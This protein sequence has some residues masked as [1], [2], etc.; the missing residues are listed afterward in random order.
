MAVRSMT[1]TQTFSAPTQADTVTN[2][3]TQHATTN[4][5]ISNGSFTGVAYTAANA[6]ESIT[7]VWLYVVAVGTGGTV[8]A[9]LQGNSAGYVDI[10]GVAVTVNTTNLKTGGWFYFR[11]A[12]AHV[13]VSG[14][15][16]YYRVKITGAGMTG[17]TTVAADGAGTA[18]SY[19]ATDNRNTAVAPGASDNLIVGGHA[20]AAVTLTLD[21]TQTIGSWSFTGG[22]NTEAASIRCNSGS[23]AID[24]A[25]GGIIADN[26]AANV[27][28]TLKGSIVIRNGGKSYRNNGV[29]VAYPSARTSI[30]RFNLN[31]V[32]GNHGFIK[33]EGGVLDWIGMVKT[34][35][36]VTP[37]TYTSGAGTAAD[38]MITSGDI[39]EV[40][41]E[42]IIFATS[43]N[44][45]NYNECE[46]RF[47]K[48]KNS[49]TSY[50]LS[51]T[52]GGAE[53]ALTY[54]HTAV[55]KVINVERNVK[56]TSTSSTA[57]YFSQNWEVTTRA[58]HTLS[59][60]SFEYVGSTTSYKEGIGVAMGEHVGFCDY[61]VFI[62]RI[63]RGFKT[64]SA[65]AQ[66]YV[67]NIVCGGVSTNT[68]SG[69]SLDAADNQ[70]LNDFVIANEKRVAIGT[71]QNAGSRNTFNRLEM[72][73]CGKDGGTTG[74][75]YAVSTNAWEF[76]NCNF[77]ACRTQAMYIAGAVITVNNCNFG[78][79]GKNQT[80]DI[81]T[82]GG[83]TLCL[84]N[85][86]NFGSDTLINGYTLMVVGSLVRF[87]NIDQ[88]AT[89]MNHEWYTS[90]GSARACMTGL[91]DTQ[92]TPA[93][94]PT[95]RIAAESSD[96]GFSWEFQVP[97]FETYSA[98]FLGLLQRN[99]TF[100]AAAGSVV[101]EI[102]LPGSITADATYTMSTTTGVWETATAGVTYGG[103]IDGMA[104][105]KI[106]AKTT[107]AGAYLYVGDLY[108]GTNQVTN[109]NV[110]YN[111]L[112]SPVMFDQ[113]G[114]AA[115]TWAQLRAA[116]QVAGSFGEYVNIN[117]SAV[118][119]AVWDENLAGHQTVLSSGRAVTLGGVPIAETTA[120]GVPTVLT[121]EL[122]AGSATNDYYNGML[123]MPASGGVAGQARPIVDYIGATKQIV[124]D[125]PW[126]SAPV[127]GDAVV[128]IPAHIHS[129]SEI[130]DAVWDE[131]AAAH[132][133]AGSTGATLTD[134]NIKTDDNQALII[135]M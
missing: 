127:A 18:F 21:G 75:A 126:T 54:T 46:H 19:Y 38:P 80:Y 29:G 135:G 1:A 124:I 24:V 78:M 105:V 11:Y 37:Q 32:S 115:A 58:N 118:I 13:V 102:W 57:G 25:Y 43:N 26:T 14:A 97:V 52:A 17:T 9:Q 103:T 86:C 116:N 71:D 4:I 96:P 7:G 5:T 69:V 85:E 53:A 77:N 95:V 2:T 66:T 92:E 30:Y 111:A 20:G 62:R 73:A 79:N 112:P 27:D 56:C 81:N 28:Y 114:N 110:W 41:D 91:T 70:T 131:S 68:V 134:T 65:V 67:G 51:N 89:G 15:A 72:N 128:I 98:S 120:V 39:G 122:A 90:Y 99:V 45:A 22:T 133:V 47:I 48:T 88:D 64:R 129:A 76:N 59:N 42:V 125:E 35:T 63:G 130:A 101:V 82:A 36:P 10:A 55:A 3:M 8:T 61:C 119:D 94:H 6:G 123:V 34:G 23:P 108:G 100:N 132:V 87:H 84:F 40:G 117:T 113:I 74:T 107:T 93:G 109:L 50:V 83:Y 60:V 121:V 16:N 44:A 49:A 33:A 12:A 104:T 106:I 31:A